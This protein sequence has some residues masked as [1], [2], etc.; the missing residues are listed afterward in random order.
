[1][2]IQVEEQV[3]TEGE[4]RVALDFFPIT[5]NSRTTGQPKSVIFSHLPFIS[6]GNRKTLNIAEVGK[7]NIHHC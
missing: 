1:M 6:K 7:D 5:H 2:Y 4:I 3:S